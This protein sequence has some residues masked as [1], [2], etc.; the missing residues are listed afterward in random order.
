[1]ASVQNLARHPFVAAIILV[2][3]CA[4]AATILIVIATLQRRPTYCVGG[5]ET[6][7]VVAV[8]ADLGVVTVAGAAPY[9]VDGSVV[10]S[11]SESRTVVYRY[12]QDHKGGPPTGVDKAALV[13]A[14]PGS[15]CISFDE[16]HDFTQY[17]FGLRNYIT[18]SEDIVSYLTIDRKSV[19]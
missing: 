13:T 1:M 6:Q 18:K 14:T 15:S 5:E 8:D 2:V 19:V 7:L 11:A 12:I 9:R 3:G 17:K 16:R 10:G 4:V